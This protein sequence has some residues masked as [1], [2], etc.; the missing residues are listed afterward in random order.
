MRCPTEGAACLVGTIE[1]NEQP[2]FVHVIVHGDGD[3]DDHTCRRRLDRSQH[4]H[5]LQCDQLIAVGNDGSG[6]DV[7]L[8]HPARPLRD[9]DGDASAKVLMAHRITAE[10]VAARLAESARGISST[11]ETLR[12]VHEDVRAGARANGTDPAHALAQGESI[13]DEARRQASEIADTAER[14]T[15]F[16]RGQGDVSYALVDINDCVMDVIDSTDAKAVASVVTEPGTVPEVFA[17]RAEVCLM[18]E[19]VVENSLQAIAEA[20]R[21]DAEI[22]IST[23]AENDRASVTIIDNGVGMTPE[24]RGRMFEPFYTASEGRT[25]VGL[26][27]TSHLVEKYGGTISVSSMAG[28]GTVTRIQLPGMSEG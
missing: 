8:G 10:C 26:S 28:G 19:K 15:S 12:N 14:L 2:A 24:V 7:D 25:G 20:N 3:L 6:G 27:S 13:V 5:R 18:L 9:L 17:S 4:L 11:L 16:S 21:E 1:A 23:S 22:R